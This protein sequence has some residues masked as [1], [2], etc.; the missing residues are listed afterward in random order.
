MRNGIRFA[1]ALEEVTTFLSVLLIEDMF[2]VLNC[3]LLRGLQFLR[4][5]LED[6]LRYQKLTSFSFLLVQ[7]PC[8]GGHL[9]CRDCRAWL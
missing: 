2:A 3:D 8:D 5:I 9:D 1:Q 6:L 7:V 4:H